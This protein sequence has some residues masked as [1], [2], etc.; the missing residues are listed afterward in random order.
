MAI[1]PGVVSEKKLRELLAEQHES[2]AVEYKDVW[3]LDDRRHVVELALAVGAMQSL[4][5]YIVVGVDG[6]GRPTGNLTDRHVTLLDPATVDD[7]IGKWVLTLTCPT[8]PH[9]ACGG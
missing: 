9:R 3:N 1:E 4:G 6:R 7:K 5:G 2:A 8:P